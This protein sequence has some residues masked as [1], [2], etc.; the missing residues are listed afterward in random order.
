MGRRMNMGEF[1]FPTPFEL[2]SEEGNFSTLLERETNCNYSCQRHEAEIHSCLEN[3]LQSAFLE[4]S[5]KI[6]DG[7]IATCPKIPTLKSINIC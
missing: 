2:V 5:G 4:G 6:N 7:V 1:S 3:S